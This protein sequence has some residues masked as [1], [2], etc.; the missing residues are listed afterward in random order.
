MTKTQKQK[1]IIKR[2]LTFV[3]EV[4]PNYELD[5]LVM[6]VELHSFQSTEQVMIKLNFNVHV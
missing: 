4:F 1:E 2:F 6:E 3:D 5:D